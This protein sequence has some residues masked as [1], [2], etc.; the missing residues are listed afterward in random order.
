MRK[1]R[2]YR[3]GKR[4]SKG[5]S[6]I[7]DFLME[8][9]IYFEKEKSFIDCLSPKYNRLRFDFYLP[10]RNILI[11]FDGIQHYK[12]KRKNS[13]YALNKY[14]LIVLHDQ[15]K[16]KYAKDNNIKLIRIPYTH[17]KFITFN[18]SILLLDFD[19]DE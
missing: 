11:E 6:V 10:N 16:N 17:F 4:V 14:N 2:F 15:I 12:V 3:N 19:E 1:K 18:L 5:E 13:T 9:K 8:H 7:Y